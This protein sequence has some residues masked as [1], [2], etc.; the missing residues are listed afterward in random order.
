MLVDTITRYFLQ[1]RNE[2]FKNKHSILS[3]FQKEQIKV[4]AEIWEKI[5]EHEFNC[6]SSVGKAANFMMAGKMDECN[7]VFE[8]L[9]TKI[10][11]L[12]NLA[13]KKIFWIGTDNLQIMREYSNKVVNFLKSNPSVEKINDFPQKLENER[14][15]I[16]KITV[17]NLK[18][19]KG[20]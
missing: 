16:M 10:D 6:L 14:P 5:I 4:L 1:N 20:I 2:V 18:K 7:A 11:E 12:N 13:S 17:D 15:D 19:M 9:N 3:D 8:E